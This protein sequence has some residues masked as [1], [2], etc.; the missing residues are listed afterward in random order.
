MVVALPPAPE[1]IESRRLADLPPVPTLRQAVL[2]LARLAR[3]P[4]E[5]AG[6]LRE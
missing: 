6:N 4:T 1:K 5:W 2:L 3:D